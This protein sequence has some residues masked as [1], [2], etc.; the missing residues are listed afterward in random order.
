EDGHRFAQSHLLLFQPVIQDEERLGTLYLKADVSAMYARLRLYG[1][2]VV[3]VMG[4]CCLVA[5]GISSVLQKSISQ[6]ILALAETAKAISDRKDY[7][8]RARKA[9]GAEMGLL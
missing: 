7:S 3:L 4:V 9:G 2:I 5:F 1:V 8:V 6:P